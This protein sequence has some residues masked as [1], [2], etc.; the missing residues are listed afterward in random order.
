MKILKLK[1]ILFSIMAITMVTIFL[2]SCEREIIIEEDVKGVKEIIIEEDIDGVKEI[3]IDEDMIK[4]LEEV[5]EYSDPE[6]GVTFFIDEN[7]PDLNDF[8]KE[9]NVDLIE[10]RSSG[11]LPCNPKVLNWDNDGRAISWNSTPSYS[12]YIE[13]YSATR[14]LGTAQVNTSS[15]CTPTQTTYVFH[16]SFICKKVAFVGYHHWGT[17]THDDC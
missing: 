15:N 11:A 10:D 2:S 13:F 16:G 7:V 5:G 4:L 8:E 1:S 17:A 14:Y 6:T 3:N 12:L 9:Q